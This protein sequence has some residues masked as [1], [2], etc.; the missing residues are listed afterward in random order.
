MESTYQ[1]IALVAFGSIVA[2]I[3]VVAGA[4][5][6]FKGSRA[7]PGERFLGGVPKGEVFSIPDVDDA[8]EFPDQSPEAKRVMERVEEFMGKF[9]GDKE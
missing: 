2:I 5:L 4:G 8:T 1:T 3:G 9:K 7:V 6:M